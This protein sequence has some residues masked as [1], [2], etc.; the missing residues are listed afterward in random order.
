MK[1]LLFIAHRVPYPPDKGERVRAFREI[2]AL[3]KHFRVTVATLTHQPSDVE[4]AAELKRW[5]E[6]VITAPAA[7]RVHRLRGE[8]R[9]RRTPN[10][11]ESNAEDPPSA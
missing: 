10:L 3:A 8:L 1:R 11:A 7:G 6:K 2:K 5:C 9:R 4:A